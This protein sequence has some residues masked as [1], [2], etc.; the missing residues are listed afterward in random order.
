MIASLLLTALAT[1]LLLQCLQYHLS[2]VLAVLPSPFCMT[3][4]VIDGEPV[5]EAI[6]W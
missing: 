1:R 5:H 2:F 6:D 3:I 4:G